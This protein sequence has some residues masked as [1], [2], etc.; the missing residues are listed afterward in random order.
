M[1]NMLSLHPIVKTRPPSEKHAFQWPPVFSTTFYLLYF[2][3]AFHL[4]TIVQLC[5]PRVLALKALVVVFV[6]VVS[7]KNHSL[8][9]IFYFSKILWAGVFATYVQCLWP[10]CGDTSAFRNFPLLT[11]GDVSHIFTNSQNSLRFKKFQVTRSLGMFSSW[12]RSRTSGR[13]SHW[14]WQE[15]GQNVE[16][17]KRGGQNVWFGQ[18]ISQWGSFLVIITPQIFTGC[19]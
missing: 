17:D 11:F 9:F 13:F 5:L 19:L 4:T 10:G 7:S 3:W 6:F 12:R 8:E 2:S 14:K 16:N 15:G 18:V 1:E